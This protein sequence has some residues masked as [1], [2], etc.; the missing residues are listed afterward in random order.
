[1][2]NDAPN[3]L[4]NGRFL[5]RQMT[6]VDR[7]AAE[8]SLAISQLVAE[9][10][11]GRLRIALPAQ[12]VPAGISGSAA[13]EALMDLPRLENLR[14]KGYFWE[15]VSLLTAA[16]DDWLLNLCNMG[17]VLRRHQVSMIHDAQV[18]TQP[19]AYSRAFR[20]IYHTLLPRIGARSALVLTVSDFSRKELEQHGVVPEGKATVVHNGVDHIDRIAADTTTLARK[21]L[22][23]GEYFL[24]LGSM[25]PHKNLPMLTELAN[26]LGPEMPPL[27]LAGGG[28]P[29]VFADAGISESGK[30]RILGRVT[31]G[32]LK[33]LYQGAMALVFPSLTEGFGLPP[34]EAMA[35]GCPTIVTTGGAV[36]EVC[37][38]ASI[39]AAPDDPR[40]WRKAMEA[41][42]NDPER[43]ARMRAEGLKRAQHFTWKRAAEI[44]LKAIEAAGVGRR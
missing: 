24:A 5:T 13:A 30:V 35:N 8:L 40:A 16:R 21:G 3:L 18:F 41:V 43:R 1:M 20:T 36:P 28:N 6:G 10:P 32:E 29:R 31:D 17:P 38:E 25:A 39:Y 14:G 33:A 9:R 27:V 15:Q 34:L 26:G 44:T 4:L 22:T 11:G 19:Q 23:E 12:D 42:A 37:A 2:K 7:V